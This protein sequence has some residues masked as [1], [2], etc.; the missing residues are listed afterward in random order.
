MIK[1]SVWVRIDN[2]M[3]NV[4]EG[5]WYRKTRRSRLERAREL[6][7]EAFNLTPILETPQEH[8]EEDIHETPTQ[9]EH[10][11]EESPQ[12]QANEA[13]AQQEQFNEEPANEE[14]VLSDERHVPYVE[15]PLQRDF[16]RIRRALTQPRIHI[17][18]IDFRFGVRGP[19]L[20]HY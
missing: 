12:E 7:R 20:L 13:P 16:D 19:V 15:M 11:E 6:V 9:E 18:E 1:S 8:A 4:D 14:D 17:L 2:R 3:R 5:E 10:I